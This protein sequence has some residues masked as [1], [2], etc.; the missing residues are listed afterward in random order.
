[1][2]TTKFPILAFS[3]IDSGGR[4]VLFIVVSQLY[5]LWGVIHRS[6]C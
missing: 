6:M 5:M 3:N 2:D 4:Y 1:M